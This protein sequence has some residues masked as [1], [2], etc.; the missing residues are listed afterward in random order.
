MRFSL[1]DL[2]DMTTR[3]TG[4]ELGYT[5]FEPGQSVGVFVMYERDLD[6]LREGSDYHNISY[7]YDNVECRIDESGNLHP[8]SIEEMFY[9]MGLDSKIAVLPK[10]HTIQQ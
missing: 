2:V 1:G 3:G 7:Y 9:P 8:N 5:T 6:S 4:E 10:L